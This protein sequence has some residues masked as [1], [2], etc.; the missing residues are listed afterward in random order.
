[1]FAIECITLA[2]FVSPMFALLFAKYFK[3]D[4]PVTQRQ[5][6]V[7][8]RRLTPQVDANGIPVCRKTHGHLNQ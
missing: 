8:R 2:V 3:L 1:M 5:R 6:H 7:M 4:V